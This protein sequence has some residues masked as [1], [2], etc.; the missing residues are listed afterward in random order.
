MGADA[1]NTE[2]PPVGRAPTIRLYRDA[3]R[4]SHIVLPVVR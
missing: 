1:D 3:Q 4:A 2:R